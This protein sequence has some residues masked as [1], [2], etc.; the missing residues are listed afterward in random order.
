MAG[1]LEGEQGAGAPEIYQV[2]QSSGEA[3][4]QQEVERIH[5]CGSIAAHGDVQIAIP[6]RPAPSRRPEQ[7]DELN[8]RGDRAEILESLD[9][10]LGRRHHDAILQD[11]RAVLPK[12]QSAWR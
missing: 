5:I 11:H 3:R 4:R 7:D 12:G 10:A 1:H 2:Q 6:P 8:G 9:E